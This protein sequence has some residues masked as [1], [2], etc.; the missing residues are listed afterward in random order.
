[1]ISTHIYLTTQFAKAIIVA[2][3]SEYTGTDPLLGKATNPKFGDYQ[4][5]V[6]MGLAKQ[7]GKPPREI[8]QKIID[9]LD[10]S[11]I[12][13]LPRIAGA[14]FLNITLKPSY[15]RDRLQLIQTDSRLGIPLTVTPQRVIVDFSS[16][17]IAKEMHVGHLRSTIIGECL[18]RVLEFQGHD[19]LR[20][21]LKRGVRGIKSC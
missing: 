12:A 13:E 11:Q 19:V 18:A 21:C 20:G 14:G 9:N 17:N 10:V 15:V 7:L 16:P 4:A 6:A 3:G 1:M 5:N 2:F 8:A